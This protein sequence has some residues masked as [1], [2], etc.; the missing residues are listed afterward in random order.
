MSSAPRVATPV[1]VNVDTAAQGCFVVLDEAYSRARR[2]P[3]PT[4]KPPAP[5][6]A[7]LPEM[8]VGA[9][10]RAGDGNFTVVVSLHEDSRP[11]PRGETGEP[12][13]KRFAVRDSTARHLDVDVISVDRKD[14]HQKWA[15]AAR[16]CRV[17]SRRECPRLQHEM[18]PLEGTRNAIDR[19]H[20][21]CCS[22]TYTASTVRL[23]PLVTYAPPPPPS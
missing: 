12:V 18:P 20:N 9:I 8:T 11:D 13:C 16:N 19:L 2:Q 3:T 21:Q 6:S 4:Y 17:S 14:P 23:A 1:H 7:S 5:C 15:N 10:W 22:Q